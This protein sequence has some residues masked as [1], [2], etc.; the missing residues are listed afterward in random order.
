MLVTTASDLQVFQLTYHYYL[1][2]KQLF[3]LGYFPIVQMMKAGE[4]DLGFYI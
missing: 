3:S 1:P 4:C 2:Q